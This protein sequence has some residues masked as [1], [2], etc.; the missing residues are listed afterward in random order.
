MGQVGQCLRLARA[1]QDAGGGVAARS[2]ARGSEI[3]ALCT[4]AP[5]LQAARAKPTSTPGGG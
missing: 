1:K 5:D 4:A 3:G 2:L